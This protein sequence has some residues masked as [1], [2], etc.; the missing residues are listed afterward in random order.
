MASIKRL[1][2]LLIVGLILLSSCRALPRLNDRRP[3]FLIILSDDQRFDTMQYMPETQ[4]RIFDQGVTFAHGYITTPLCC[5]SR[6][7]ILTGRYAHNTGVRVNTDQLNQPTFVDTLHRNGYYTGLVGKYLNSW[8]GE[9]R[10]EFDYWVSFFRG[11][12][13]Y[14]DPYL[15]VNGEWADHQ[16]YISDLLG[17]YA[18]DFIRQAAPRQQPFMLLLAAN[19]PH[20]PADPAVEDQGLLPDLPLWRPASY[21]EADVSDKPVWLQDDLMDAAL[22]KRV[23]NFRRKQILSLFSLDRSIAEV[24]QALQD[25]GELDNTVVIYLSDNGMLWGEHR[26]LSKNSYYEEAVRVP[27]ALRYP[28]L[29]SHPYFEQRLVANIDICPTLYQL[30][31]IPIPAGVDGLSLVGLLQGGPWR[32]GLLI[33]GWPPRG[34]YAGIH[35]ERYLYVETRDDRSEFYDLEHDP[36]QLQ[37]AI[38]DP[39]YREIIAG[40]KAELEK[41]REPADAPPPP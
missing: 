18:V 15:N 34:I 25:S 28:P 30:A 14:F 19:A 35:T 36:F 37:N 3:N 7:G 9:T 32:E 5:P 16:G 11:E 13:R 6:A 21:N 1:L 26:E 10:P 38:D 2:I 39:A 33:E 23:D 41:V 31:G 24:M 4:A 17:E 8:D 20:Q 22:I 29:V 27:F 12:S 40:L